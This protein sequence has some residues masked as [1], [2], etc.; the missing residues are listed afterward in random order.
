M[1][2]DRDRKTVLLAV[3]SFLAIALLS[4]LPAAADEA[5]NGSVDNLVY[6]LTHKFQDRETETTTTFVALGA[7]V[8]WAFL[9]GSHTVTHGTGP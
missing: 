9:G 7:T 5:G 2:L 6:V 1:R 8:T 3:S 4:S